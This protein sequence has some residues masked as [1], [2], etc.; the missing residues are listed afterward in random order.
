MKI[1]K[2]SPVR[3]ARMKQVQKKRRNALNGLEVCK[4]REARP[5]G[6]KE[7][8]SCGGRASEWTWKPRIKG[9]GGQ[10]ERWKH[11]RKGNLG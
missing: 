7:R 5:I 11:E 2:Q 4:S 10:V 1:A 9:A 8:V 3:P 6:D